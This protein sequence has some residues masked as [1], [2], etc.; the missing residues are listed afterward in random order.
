M[1]QTL[2]TKSVYILS[3]G[4]VKFCLLGFVWL[5]RTVVNQE[6]ICSDL[7]KQKRFNIIETV[8]YV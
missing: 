8:W 3:S 6:D 7:S 2:K 4:E 5:R 1:R